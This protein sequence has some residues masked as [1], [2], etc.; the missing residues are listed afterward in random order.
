M[1]KRITLFIII[2][3]LTSSLYGCENKRA[4]ITTTVYP[5]KYIVEQLAGNKVDVEYL[6]ADVFIQ[7]AGM[8]DN[9]QEILEKTTLFVYIGELEPYM[10]IYEIDIQS[11]DYDIINLA[12]LSAIDLFR[13]YTTIYTENGMKVITDG[14]YYEGDEFSL[15]DVY[16]KDPF[17]WLDPIAMSSIASTIKSWLQEKYPEDTLYYENNF[18]SLQADLVRMDAEFQALNNLRG[19]KIVTIGATFGN[20]QK[21]YGVEVF[22]LVLSKYG[23]LPTEKQLKLIKET[24]QENEVE[25]IAYDETLPDDY[26][27]LGDRITEELGLTRIKLSSLTRLSDTDREKNKDYM[28]IMYENLNVLESAFKQ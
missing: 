3:M 18:K 2:A 26:L 5:V 1:K 24:I 21:A 23:V 10:D 11:Y 16:N 15:V 12:T 6:T 25:Y 8:V 13:R 14:D 19:I 17:I 4:T 7:R 22:P 9:Y 27:E 28:T 20:W